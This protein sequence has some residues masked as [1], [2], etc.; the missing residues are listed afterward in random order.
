MKSRMLYNRKNSNSPRQERCQC[1]QIKQLVQYYNQT[2]ICSS[3][4]YSKNMLVATHILNCSNAKLIPFKQVLLTLFLY[5]WKY[6]IITL[7]SFQLLL[8]SWYL[9]DPWRVLAHVS[10]D[11]C[12]GGY[13]QNLASYNHTFVRQKINNGRFSYWTPPA[14]RSPQL[15]QHSPW[16]PVI[17][18]S[19]LPAAAGPTTLSNCIWI[20]NR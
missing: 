8:H 9:Q 20:N 10:S 7:F 1:K 15:L 19:A 6:Q 2:I 3:K 14:S 13:A 16:L 17:A 11:S 12:T 4:Y 18:L 5:F